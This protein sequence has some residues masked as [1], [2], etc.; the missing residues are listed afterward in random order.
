MIDVIGDFL[1]L[2]SEELINLTERGEC[3]IQ[4]LGKRQGVRKDV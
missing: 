4:K 3:M 2:N 1:K